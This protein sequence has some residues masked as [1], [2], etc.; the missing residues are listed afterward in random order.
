MSITVY[1]ANN[2]PTELSEDKAAELLKAGQVG[3]DTSAHF[4][5]LDSKGEVWKVPGTGVATALQNGWTLGTNF[6]ADAQRRIAT[7][8]AERG[9]LETGGF[10]SDIALGQNLVGNKLEQMAR[11][12]F[13][14]GSAEERATQQIAEENH[15]I[16]TKVGKVIGTGVGTAAQLLA[17]K[18]GSAVGGLAEKAILKGA[19]DA[20]VKELTENA[21]S[22]AAQTSLQRQLAAKATN[23]GVQG[24][25]LSSPQ[26]LTATA[27]GDPQLAAESL[28]W[29][30]GLNAVFGAGGSL[31][32]RSVS[33]G[34]EAGRDLFE[35]EAPGLADKAVLKSAG[36]DALKGMPETTARMADSLHELNT[37]PG[38]DRVEMRNRIEEAA[39]SSKEA[40]DGMTGKLDNLLEE[41]EEL[42]QHA[43]NPT[44]TAM[45]MERELAPGLELPSAKTARIE[46][47]K[48]V[49]SVSPPQMSLYHGETVPFTEA[50]KIAD[51]FKLKELDPMASPV[52]QVRQQAAQIVNRDFQASIANTINAAK[53]QG[54][55]DAPLFTDFLKQA[56]RN[57]N[58]LDLMQYG[59]LPKETGGSAGLDYTLGGALLGAAHGLKGGITG[60]A[61]G[62][63][64]S[65]LKNLIKNIAKD[66]GLN[67]SAYVLNQLLKD[68][69]NIPFM[70][71]VI[72]HQSVKAVNSHLDTIGNLLT[73]ENATRGAQLATDAIIKHML[74]SDGTGLSKDQQFKQHAE[75]LQELINNPEA[76]HAHLSPIIGTFENHAP[77][78]A[79]EYSNAVQRAANHLGAAL[80]KNPNPVQEPFENDVEWKPTKQ[81]LRD[82]YEV[83]ET[84][85]NPGKAVSD[86]V[87]GRASK[88]QID[89]LQIVY[90]AYTEQ[91]KARVIQHGL[92]KKAKISNEGLMGISF[93]TG[94]PIGRSMKSLAS[95]QAGYVPAGQQPSPPKRG[96]AK[97]KDLTSWD[98]NSKNK[99]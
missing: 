59:S 33:K 31:I 53:D 35:S 57:R 39:R 77:Q 4:N 23:Y 12:K 87:H 20:A 9:P 1:D 41:N 70:G 18:G 26:I 55:G 90:P 63:T 22:E 99:E 80:P 8:G 21:I 82:Y 11:D 25:A 65:V 49:D 84:I 17:L 97:I 47:T 3:V 89:T 30:T 92:D 79:V 50:A 19:E 15:P 10:A 86:V 45:N 32:G 68:T 93:L 67:T 14:G 78:L 66:K 6:N 91:V 76:M 52:D 58:M 81:Q 46:L 24:L 13:A 43:F 85:H 36:V 51:Q 37:E 16:A 48:L 28:L 44:R 38:I 27:L 5:M 64:V 62:A 42:K 96:A 54:L 73:K 83:A 71:S 95:Y 75:Q 2:V 69:E 7:E 61:A 40:I 88:K 94:Q 34:M 60:M 74:N 72:A 56:E 98:V 29:N